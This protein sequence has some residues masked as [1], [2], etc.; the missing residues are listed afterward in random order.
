MS[1]MLKGAANILS[2]RSRQNSKAAAPAPQPTAPP[3]SVSVPDSSRNSHRR[4]TSEP[5]PHRE[6]VEAGL[7]ANG[8][9]PD[10]ATS[11]RDSSDRTSGRG[12]RPQ[13]M[14]PDGRPIIFKMVSQALPSSVKKPI[15]KTVNAVKQVVETSAVKLNDVVKEHAS[16]EVAQRIAKSTWETVKSDVMI[17]AHASHDMII[18]WLC[19]GPFKA[20]EIEDQY[21]HWTVSRVAWMVMMMCGRSRC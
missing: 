19:P 14:S 12:S 8:E 4:V 18:L 2:P 15:M 9:T 10:G 3:P 1:G 11:S 7:L 5:T 13:K 20:L 17:S 16:P 21:R 6:D